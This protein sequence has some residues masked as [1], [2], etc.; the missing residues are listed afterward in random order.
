MIQEGKRFELGGSR[1]KE[2]MKQIHV[3]SDR[4]KSAEETVR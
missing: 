4:H 3:D 1:S 2:T